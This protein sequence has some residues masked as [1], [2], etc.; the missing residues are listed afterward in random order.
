MEAH[1]GGLRLQVLSGSHTVHISEQLPAPVKLVLV[2]SE[3]RNM[4]SLVHGCLSWT[5]CHAD[6][7][8]LHG[9]YEAV[10]GSPKAK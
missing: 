1:C 2:V 8:G 4:E 9:K 6:H 3:I 5:F 7:S 10:D